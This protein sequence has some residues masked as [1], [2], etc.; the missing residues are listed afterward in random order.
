MNANNNLLF[1]QG[2]YFCKGNFLQ[3]L[4]CNVNNYCNLGANWFNQRFVL[5]TVVIIN[6]WWVPFIFFLLF[7]FAVQWCDFGLYKILIPNSYPKPG[8]INCQ[9]T[10]ISHCFTVI[11]I[12]V[13]NKH[14]LLTQRA[15]GYNLAIKGKI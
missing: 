1:S 12:T 11:I 3:I 10:H 6:S 13:A 9:C 14:F 7:Y 4:C 2:K 8:I 15:V 5:P